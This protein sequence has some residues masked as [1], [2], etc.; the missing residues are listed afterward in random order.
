[1]ADGQNLLLTLAQR[2]AL[3]VQY[4]AEVARARTLRSEVTATRLESENAVQRAKALRDEAQARR[5][6]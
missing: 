1:M 6:K 4:D 3:R 5:G 2:R